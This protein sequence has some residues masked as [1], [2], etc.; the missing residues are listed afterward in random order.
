MWPTDISIQSAPATL[1][2]CLPLEWLLLLCTLSFIQK[3]RNFIFYFVKTAF[4][5]VVV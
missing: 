5:L 1:Y 2:S 3:C 4:S